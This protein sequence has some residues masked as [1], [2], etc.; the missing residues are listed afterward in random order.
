MGGL[1]EQDENASWTTET[2]LYDALNIYRVTI[3]I[4]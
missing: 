4:Y 2:T 1:N 3:L